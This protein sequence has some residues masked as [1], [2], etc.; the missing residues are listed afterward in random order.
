MDLRRAF[1]TSDDEPTHGLHSFRLQGHT[2]FEPSRTT[3]DRLWDSAAA[4]TLEHPLLQGV[5][6][7]KP[8]D[9]KNRKKHGNE[10]LGRESFL[11]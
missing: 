4:E 10:T 5:H 2:V 1:A 9:S 11:A 3:C 7:R 8:G 6:S